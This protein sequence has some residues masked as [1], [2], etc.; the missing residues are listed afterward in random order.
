[1]IDSKTEIPAT[2]IF[3]IMF[4]P[5]CGLEETQPNQFC[6]ACGIE[7]RIIRTAIEKP[8]NIT[9][10]AVFARDEIGRAIAS[11][12]REMKSARDLEKVAEDVL[13]HIEKFLES[14]EEKRMR[15]IRKGVVCASIGVGASIGFTLASF[16]MSDKGVL[17][18]VGAGIV[19]FFIGLSLILNAMLF[20]VPK[21]SLPDKSNDAENQRGLDAEIARTDELNAPQPNKLF[22]SVTEH[23]THHLK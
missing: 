10:S 5:S 2:E 15:R 11:K 21:N 22:S 6:R 16:L 9:T 20:T 18:L 7:L 1:L 19:V 3:Q 17:I 14:P 13:P 23:T 12:I 8:D 4:C